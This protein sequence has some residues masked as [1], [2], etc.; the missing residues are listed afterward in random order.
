LTLTL[1]TPAIF[2]AGYRPDWLDEDLQGEPPGVAGLRLQLVAAA[3]ERWQPHSGWDLAEQA[4]RATRKLV[5]A[6][7]TYWF[8]LLDE[9]DDGALASLWL[10]SLCDDEQDRRDGYGLA[11]PAPW[12]PTV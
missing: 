1:L 2:A 10:A 5:G 9:P 6:G 11:L 4:P 8:R 3:L 7:A 12:I